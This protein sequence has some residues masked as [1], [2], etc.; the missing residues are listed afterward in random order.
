METLEDVDPLYE[1][2]ANFVLYE[3]AVQA[4]GALRV[5]AG[6]ASYRLR[7]AGA[8]LRIAAKTIELINLPEA[9]PNLTFL[10]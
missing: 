2:G 5:W 1:V 10:L 9:V 6:R 4:T 7:R 3:L 8:D